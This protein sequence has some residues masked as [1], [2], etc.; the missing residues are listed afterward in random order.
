MP[1]E[2]VDR[3][4]D[5]A[6][7]AARLA[8]LAD[9]SAAPGSV[10]GLMADVDALLVGQQDRVYAMCMRFVGNPEHAAELAQD[11]MLRAYQK[12]PGFRGD[13]RFSTWILSITRYECLNALRKRGDHLTD[14][15]VIEPTDPQRSVLSSLRTREREELLRGAARA[16]LDPIEQEAVTLRYTEH[17][18]LDEITRTLGLTDA[19]GA[20]GLLQR[21]KRKL[22][23][24]LRRRLA[25]LG[26][27]SSFI[28][29]SIE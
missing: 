5:A 16:V 19:S 1:L 13:S 11:V 12:L 10:E 8:T 26:H 29:G 14:D 9:G 18:P 25:E 3:V 4:P 22:Q 15:G 28:R 27:G 2:R 23:R 21:C 17:L 6:E 20:R 7:V 24:E